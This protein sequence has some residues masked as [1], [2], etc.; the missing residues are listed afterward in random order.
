MLR[1]DRRRT[2]MVDETTFQ[3]ALDLEPHN[4]ALRLVFAD[5][6]EERGDPRAAGYRWMG[7][8]EK[9]PF[10]WSRRHCVPAFRWSGDPIPILDTFDW[11]LE[12]GGASWDVPRHCQVPRHF[13]ELFKAQCSWLDFKT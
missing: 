3:R 11:Y 7:R 6:L 13:R 10:D 12:D 5:W 1:R 8:H 9:W 2:A 4:W